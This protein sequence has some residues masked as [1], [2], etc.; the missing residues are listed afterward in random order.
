MILYHGTNV[1]FSDINLAVGKNKRDF[2]KGF[3]TTTL[4]SQAHQWAEYKCRQYLTDT[5]YIYEYDID[6]YTGLNVKTFDGYNL[7]WLEFIKENRIKDGINHNFD[8]V[9]GPVAD[10][11]IRRTLKLYL[12]A[13]V[14][15]EWTLHKLSYN[16][17]NNQISFH[18]EIAL[19]KLTFTGRKEWKI[20]KPQ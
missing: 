15:A 7:E 20:N 2:G 8:I 14:S 13:R 16:K 19:S 18:T 17:P 3:Y 6:D 9:I 12:Q 11:N 5:A 4:E 10:D 1:N